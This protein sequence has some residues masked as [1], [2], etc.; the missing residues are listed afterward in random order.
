MS[1]AIIGRERALI[2]VLAE[3]FAHAAGRRHETTK[4]YHERARGSS[5]E[6]HLY[7]PDG[8]PTGMVAL[9]TVEFDRFD[10]ALTSRPRRSV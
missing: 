9:V 7:D 3:Q 10:S 5:F 6:V 2:T 4:P 1:R 8:E